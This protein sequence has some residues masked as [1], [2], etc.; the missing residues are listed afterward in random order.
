MNWQKTPIHILDFEGNGRSGVVEFGV[1]TVLG[2]EVVSARTEFCKPHGRIPR[3]EMELH[4]I[5]NQAVA[6]ARP[7]KAYWDYFSRLRQ[8]GPFGAHHASVEESLLKKTWSHSRMAP[9]FLHPGQSVAEWG[10][11]VDT[12]ELYAHLFPKVP[13][14]GLGKLVETFGLLGELEA[15]GRQFCPKPRRKFHAALYD[16]LASAVLLLH[17]GTYEE[18]AEGMTLPW[19]LAQSF[20]SAAKRQKALQADLFQ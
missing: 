7:L 17:L 20:A 10:P 13:G 1:A 3:R 18:L 8:E 15:L 9:D 4:G 6:R 11:W 14:H 12:K 16:A 5:T 19:L 2:G